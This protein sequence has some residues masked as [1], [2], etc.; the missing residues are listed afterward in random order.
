MCACVL[1]HVRLFVTPWTVAP[2]LL[3]PWNFL[4][5][6]TGMS[7]HCLLQL[8]PFTHY[9]VPPL[10][11]PD[12]TCTEHYL[13]HIFFLS[14]RN[15]M[16]LGIVIVYMVE[17]SSTMH[18]CSVA[19]VVSYSLLPHELYSPAGSSVH[20]IFQ[21]RILDWVAISFFRGSSWPGDR[22]RVSRI[23]GR[24]FTVGATGEAQAAS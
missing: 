7:C 22:A 8:L 3:S 13:L 10:P 19:S 21:A 6:N 2:R 12:S 23:A 9:L 16:A 17:T 15:S 18:T 24:F 4:G 1:S 11:T 14:L 5:K 20:G